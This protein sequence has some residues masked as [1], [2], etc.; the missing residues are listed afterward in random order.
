M[1]SGIGPING[2]R[3]QYAAVTSIP[4]KLGGFNN[5]ADFSF[6]YYIHH[7]SAGASA[8]CNYSETETDGPSSLKMFPP[9]Q[10]LSK[11]N[12]INPILFLQS[13]AVKGLTAHLL[14]GCCMK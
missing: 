14:T 6:G 5:K 10:R 12:T 1:L 13:P 4:R 8:Y 9:F 7:R 3:L 11:D 2:D